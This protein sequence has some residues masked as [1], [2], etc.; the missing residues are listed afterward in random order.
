M[1]SIMKIFNSD[2]TANNSAIIKSPRHDWIVWLGFS[3]NWT[4]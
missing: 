1:L 4:V 2:E 3:E